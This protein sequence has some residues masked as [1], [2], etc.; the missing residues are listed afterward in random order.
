MLVYK[1]LILFLL[2]TLLDFKRL[3]HSKTKKRCKIPVYISNDIDSQIDYIKLLKLCNNLL[4]EECLIN[5]IK[6]VSKIKHIKDDN[7]KFVYYMLHII[8][9]LY[10]N[11]NNHSFSTKK[12]F[13]NKF[14]FYVKHKEYEHLNES[15]NDMLKQ[16]NPVSELNSAE[17]K[18]KVELFYKEIN[19]NS[20]KLSI[21][22]ECENLKH[23]NDIDKPLLSILLKICSFI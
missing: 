14:K 22:D 7:L 2:F 6:A 18:R 16:N 1:L 19:Q 4:N 17:L 15:L 21:K 3:N 23:K 10:D 20:R 12:Y 5:N 13:E 11:E 8:K 9:Y